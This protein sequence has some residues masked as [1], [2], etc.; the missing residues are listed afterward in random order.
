MCLYN[1]SSNPS[2]TFVSSPGVFLEQPAF[3]KN[4][5]RIYQITNYGKVKLPF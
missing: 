4:E 2:E 5:M 1:R 3:A